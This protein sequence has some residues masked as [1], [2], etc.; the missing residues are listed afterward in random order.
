[1]SLKFALTGV[2][3]YVAPR[4]MKAILETNNDLVAA[5]DP[6]DSV[7]ILDKFFPECKFFTEYE[8]FDRHLEKLR[9]N[10][11][12][13]DYISVCSPNY[14]HDAHCRLAMRV[15]SDV[16]CEKPVVLNPWNL[17]QLSEIENET[18]KRI[19]VVLQL[20]YHPELLKIRNSL[21]NKIHN[22]N[23]H[24]ITPRG[25]WYHT[26]WKGDVSK[27]GGLAT[28]IGIHLFDLAMWY[29]GKVEICTVKIN[30]P[31]IVSGSLI[32]ERAKV[33]FYLS[34]NNSDLCNNESAHRSITIDNKPLRFDDIFDDLHVLVYKDILNGGGMGIEDARPSIELVHRIRSA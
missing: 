4:H 2:A 12:G 9:R 15:G 34:T 23:I 10:K 33:D 7:G 13:V 22:V 30:Q 18:G 29:F 26:S 24:Y 5:L 1:M 31:N 28:N 17:D 20:R 21:D 16:I 11:M 14:L 8:R 6:H 19:Y 25:P 3:G 32:L 27:S